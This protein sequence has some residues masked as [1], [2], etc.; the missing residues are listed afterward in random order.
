M[1]FKYQLSKE[2]Y[3]S[4]RKAKR[5]IFNKL[6]EKLIYWSFENFM[7][8]NFRRKDITYYQ[9]IL[10]DEYI[11]AICDV[12]EISIRWEAVKDI[13]INS[14]FIKITYG[15]NREFYIL[16]EPNTFK[17]ENEKIQF[18]NE[19][20]KKSKDLKKHNYPINFS[21]P[22]DAFYKLDFNFSFEDGQYFYIYER[23][24][25]S[26][27]KFIIATNKYA[28]IVCL[29]TLCLAGYQVGYSAFI[30]FL[31]FSLLL[32][33][34][35]SKKDRSKSRAKEYDRLLLKNNDKYSPSSEKDVVLTKE[36][37]F[38]QD[39]NVVVYIRYDK[40]NN[41]NIIEVRN[42]LGILSLDFVIF[43]IPMSVF[44]DFFEK[45]SFI[46]KINCSKVDVQYKN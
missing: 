34:Y 33:L 27:G 44:K 26:K 23:K 36:G 4:S 28:L 16:T 15:L 1:E 18:I 45:D 32:Y 10:N 6:R 41:F 2:E 35:Y 20:N 3:I 12:Y 31:I 22:E 37:A 46:K 9:V 7:Y 38:F 25:S 21:A 13:K 30:F 40:M 24:N 29:I 14:T 39:N 42:Y 43:W 17:N 19:I 8:T 11:T 5:K